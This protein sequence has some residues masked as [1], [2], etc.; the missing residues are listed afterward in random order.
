MPAKGAVVD[1][2]T[3]GENLTWQI[4]RTNISNQYNYL[5]ISG[6]GPM[7][8]DLGP[9]AFSSGYTNV[10]IEEG[11]V[12]GEAPE[13]IEDLSR[14]GVAVVASGITVGK[15]GKVLAQSM[16]EADVKEGEEVNTHA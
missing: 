14:W 7:Y 12:V 4:L 6:S 2:G 9:G 16:I 1:S 13:E 3:C 5:V 15:N 8:D 11:A 10:V